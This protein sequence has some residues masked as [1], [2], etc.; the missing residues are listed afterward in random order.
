MRKTSLKLRTSGSAFE[1]GKHRPIVLEFHP[2]QADLLH[3]RAAG[4]KTRYTITT[5]NL[6]TLLAQREVEAARRRRGKGRGRP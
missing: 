2:G 4:L 6:Y 5:G 1:L 3:V